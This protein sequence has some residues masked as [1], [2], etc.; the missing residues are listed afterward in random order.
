VPRRK[1]VDV[2]QPVA[3]AAAQRSYRFTDKRAANPKAST[4][5]P[6][7]LPRHSPAGKPFLS[8]GRKY[9]LG[10]RGAKRPRRPS[11]LASFTQGGETKGL[12]VSAQFNSRDPLR[13]PEQ[14]SITFCNS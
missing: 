14:P 12:R 6:R 1:L 4:F 7:Q 10:V 11:R 13:N 3:F 2:G 5:S 9:P 8:P